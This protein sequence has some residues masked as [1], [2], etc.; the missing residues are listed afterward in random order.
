MFTVRTQ[1]LVRPHT[2]A[3]V[4]ME[5]RVMSVDSEDMI[6]QLPRICGAIKAHGA[7]LKLRFTHGKSICELEIYTI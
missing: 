6:Q 1:L 4:D 3:A 2:T 5:V 7:T